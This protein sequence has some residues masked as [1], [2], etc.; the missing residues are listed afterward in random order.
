[1]S[2]S[3]FLVELGTEELPPTALLRLSNAFTTGVVQG[4]EKAGLE[5]GEVKSY[6]TPRRLAI[7]VDSL[8]SE[9]P[10]RSQERRGPAV[11]AAFDSE[12]HPTKAASGFARSCGVEVADLERMSTDQ[13]EWLAY[14]TTLPPVPAAALL[15]GIVSDSLAKLPIPKRM[16]WGDSDSEF[17]RP[18]RWLL[19]LMGGE[20]VEAEILG[21]RAGNLTHGHRFHA[22]DPLVINSSIEYVDA[23]RERGHV[24]AN[25]AERQSLVRGQVLKAAQTLNGNVVIDDGLLEEVTALTEW[26]C[27]VVG[28]FEERFLEVPA[29]ALIATMASNQKYFHLLDHDGGLLPNFIAVA[30]IE[31]SNPESVRHGNERVVRPRLA[32]A[33]FFFNT[34]LKTPLCDRLDMLESV[35]FQKTLGTLA[36]KSRRVSQLAGTLVQEMGENTE[37]VTAATR[38]G[39]LCK[40]DLVTEMVGEFPELQGTMGGRYA[41]ASGE[42]PDVANAVGEA[43][44]PRFAGDELPASTAGKAVA[45]ADRLDT[46]TGIFGIG[47]T[48]KGDKDPYALRRAALGVLRIIIE[49]G[50]N[51][52]LANALSAAAH[53]HSATLDRHA[54]ATDVFDF[55]LDRLRAYYADQDITPQVFSA[56]HAKRPTKPLDFAK[57]ISAVNSFRAMPEAEALAAAN[58][59]IQNILRQ[60]E[61]TPPETLDETLLKE[62]AEQTLASQVSSLAPSVQSKLDNADYQGALSEL[63]SLREAVD[64]FFDSVRVM[65]DDLAVKNNRLALLASM[66]TLFGHTADI[67]KLQD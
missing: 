4:L 21:V 65:D 37:S 19:M 50:L 25:F 3:N 16:R 54:V 41:A 26:P 45:I 18:V 63:A 22:P 60:A 59:R 33:E 14:R 38:A 56:V 6:A 58:K 67:S 32:D 39:L 1:M 57:R 5:H 48:P 42:S 28:S 24:V 52:D 2:T 44:L 55:M 36:D 49:G 35:V 29:E 17:V 47:Q 11:K 43:Y 23:L 51:I 46:L 12:G 20:V 34:D 8:A 13:G 66:G 62:P 9:Q 64:N 30:N 7:T 27:A 61:T 40:C 31:S 53:A 15:P 10:E